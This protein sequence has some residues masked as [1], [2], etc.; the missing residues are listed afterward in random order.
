M[1]LDTLSAK[2]GL[3]GRSMNADLMTEAMEAGFVLGCTLGL[4]V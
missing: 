1:D 4:V 2:A 3:E